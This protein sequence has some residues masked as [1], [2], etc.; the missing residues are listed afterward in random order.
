MKIFTLNGITDSGKTTTIENIIKELKH[1]GYSVGSV[2]DIHFE[3]FELDSEGKNTYRHKMA[4]SSLVTAR[5]MYETDVLFQHKESLQKI[6]CFYDYDY[7][8]LEGVL[9]LDVP[10][11][12]TA[13]EELSDFEK[14]ELQKRKLNNTIAWSGR[15]SNVLSEY[16]GLPVFNAE[17]NIKEF[18]DYI[19]ENVSDYKPDIGFDIEIKINGDSLNKMGKV[20]E[21]DANNISSIQ[22]LLMAKAFGKEI[23]EIEVLKKGYKPEIFYNSKRNNVAK[24]IDSTGKQVVVKYCEDR[25]LALKEAAHLNK[26]YDLGVCVPQVLDVIVQAIVLE[27]IEGST[28]CDSLEHMEK[29]GLAYEEELSTLVSWLIKFYEVNGADCSVGDVNLRNFIL[30]TS[31]DGKNIKSIV[32][33]DFEP[34][35]N[36]DGTIE[37][38]LGVIKAYLLNYN[39]PNTK[40]K[41]KAAEYFLSNFEVQLRQQKISEELYNYKLNLEMVDESYQKELGKIKKRR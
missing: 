35:D 13:H 40:W 16:D 31:P 37:K 19:E 12:L 32:G 7:I 4:G 17:N 5:G 10:Q 9:D 21:E 22:K 20:H 24:A 8:I 14:S 1:R 41:Q 25:E 6:L 26:L 29:S 27:H 11:I 36:Y 30:K 23:T 3:D 38:D 18:V 33:V 39:P 15:I 2:K 34:T 28:L